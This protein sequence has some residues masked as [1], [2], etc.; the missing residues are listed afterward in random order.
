MFWLARLKMLLRPIPPTPTP[1]TFS[2]SLGGVNPRPRTC[3][4]TTASPA[5]AAAAVTNLRLDR[6]SRAVWF[7]A[8][9]FYSLDVRLNVLC[10]RMVVV[11]NRKRV[12]V[13]RFAKPRRQQALPHS[14]GAPLE[15]A[16]LACAL[17]PGSLL[18]SLEENHVVRPGFSNNRNRRL[19][20]R[21]RPRQ[22]RP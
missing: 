22:R 19:R 13:Q 20:T 6:P 17:C 5:P 14:K 1:A 7:C 2:R 8:V 10:S 4:G 15:C 21:A 11:F 18:P 12:E 16:K 9:I 3:L